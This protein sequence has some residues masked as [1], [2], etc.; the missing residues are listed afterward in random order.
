MLVEGPARALA[1]TIPVPFRPMPKRF[2]KIPDISL[3][4]SY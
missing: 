2:L 3:D 4:V 1:T